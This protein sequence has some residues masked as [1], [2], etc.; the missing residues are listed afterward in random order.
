MRHNFGLRTRDRL[1]A[2][3]NWGANMNRL[4]RL[5]ALAAV[6]ATLS[7]CAPGG[8]LVSQP[9][10]S[11]QR[12][13]GAP[14]APSELALVDARSDKVFSTGILKAQLSVAEGQEMDPMKYLADN[15]QG[16]L[17]SRGVPMKVVR[18]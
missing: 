8:Y 3:F 17:G 4:I 2:T 14:P 13:D 16:E 6:A 5:L 7:G 10:P 15:L 12:F 9:A 1:P 18:D 11:A